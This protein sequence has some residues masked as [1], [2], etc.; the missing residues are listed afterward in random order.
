M[1]TPNI[2]IYIL[3]YNVAWVL[4]S[5][6]GIQPVPSPDKDRGFGVRKSIR[7]VKTMPSKI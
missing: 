2:H 6:V 5:G 4:Y 7:L 1:Q 3:I